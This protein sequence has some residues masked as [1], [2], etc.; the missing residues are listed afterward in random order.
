MMYMTGIVAPIAAP[1][2]FVVVIF[3]GAFF[4]V[5]LFLVVMSDSYFSIQAEIR[6]ERAAQSV[7]DD[8]EEEA[9]QAA[10]GGALARVEGALRGAGA[11]AGRLLPGSPSLAPY[12]EHRRFE[13]LMVVLILLNTLVMALDYYG[14]HKSAAYE[15]T[16]KGL[17]YV[18]TFAF[19]IEMLF[20][21]GALGAAAYFSVFFN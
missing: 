9:Q 3:F 14:A 5:N 10:K 16:L 6:N 20:K 8:A 15:D 7:R 12:A 11:A 19:L 4:V 21:I 2:F 1:A 13:T 18:F 17:N